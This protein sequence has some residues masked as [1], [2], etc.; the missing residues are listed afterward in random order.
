MAFPLTWILENASAPI[1]YR[2]LV[3]V[4]RLAERDD[5]ALAGMPY[6]HPPALTLAVT[7]GVDGTWHDRMLG[8][9]G[10]GEPWPT[11]VGTIPAVLRLLEYGWDRESPPLLRARRLLFRLLAEDEDPAF[12]FELAGEAGTDEDL[13]RRGR[14]ILR[15]AA[16]AVL[17]HAGYERDPRLRGAALRILAPVTEYLRSPLAQKPWVRVGNRQVLSADAA[18]PSVHLL[19][20]LAHMP[21]FCSEHAEQLDRIYDYVSQPLPRQEPFQIVG[22]HIIEQPHLVLGEPI[23]SRVV[24]DADAPAAV[25]WLELVARLGFLRRNEHWQRLFERFVTDM[26]RGGIWRPRKG[27]EAPTT[28]NPYIWPYFPLDPGDEG[29]SRWTDLT[30]RLGLIARLA[31]RP[32]ELL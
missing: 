17:A 24:A 26:G 27:D 22:D 5:V 18:P 19:R 9:P 15:E 16:A 8:V 12:L 11:G 14:A 7:Q 10:P 25:V 29:A 4:A 20:M 21:L 31:G 32:V 13:V 1:R 2:S 6:A 28:T 23:P 30:F 3:E